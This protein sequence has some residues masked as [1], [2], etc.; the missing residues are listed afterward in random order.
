MPSNDPAAP[1]HVCPAIRIHV[2]D[3]VQPPGIGIPSIADMGAHQTIV[4]VVLAANSSE[5]TA[6]IACS[7]FRSET[8]RRKIHSPAVITCEPS[9]RRLCRRDS[10]WSIPWRAVTN[11]VGALDGAMGVT[12][13]AGFQ[14]DWFQP[15]RSYVGSAHTPARSLAGA[16]CAPPFCGQ[17]E[18]NSW[19]RPRKLWSE[20]LVWAC[21][22]GIN[23]PDVLPLAF[24]PEPCPLP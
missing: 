23:V 21:S 9:F 16:L 1:A 13:V 2:I 8:L 7:A 18:Q 5:E 4:N 17:R 6:R 20:P 10:L 14:M 19:H 3:I 15:H 24:F 11:S 22:A 12:S